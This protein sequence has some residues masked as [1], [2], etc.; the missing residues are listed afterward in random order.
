MHSMAS[1]L[2]KVLA[3]RLSPHLDKMV[4]PSHSA[5]IKGRTIYDN[6]QYV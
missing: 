5:F 3:N 2:E 6:F 1:I 4:S